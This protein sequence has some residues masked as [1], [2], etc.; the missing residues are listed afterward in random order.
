MKKARPR[1]GARARRSL[2]VCGAT[3]AAVLGGVIE[4]Q[5]HAALAAPA[6]TPAPTSPATDP[7]PITRAVL[8]QNGIGY[9]ERRGA[10][11]GD[12]VTLSVRRDQVADFLKSLTVVDLTS[13]GRAVAVALPNDKTQEKQLEDLPPQ[14]REQGGVLAL[15]QA[16]RGASATLVTM[17][18]QSVNGRIAGVE[19]ISE[20][21]KDAQGGAN[22]TTS[23]WRVTL[24][25]DGKTLESY[26]I[27]EI[28]SLTIDD[29]NLSA[30]LDKALDVDL[31]EEAWAPVDMDVELA[32]A[33]THDIELSYV[34]EMPTWRPAYRLV[35]GDDGKALLQGWAVV[36]NVSGDDWD[37]VKLSLTAGTPLAFAYDLYT[38][39]Y[40][41]RP[42]LT[43]PENEMAQVAPAIALGG[44]AQSGEGQ[45]P[46]TPMGG[47]SAPEGV[48][49]QN[50]YAANIP[51]PVPAANIEQEA[52]GEAA[53]YDEEDE[54]TAQMPMA[55]RP[56]PPPPP[57]VTKQANADNYHEIS[58]ADL[59]KSFQALVSSAGV[60]ALF[61]YDLDEPVSV[62]DRQ[63]ALVSIVSKQV[64]G[65]DVLVYGTTSGGA[66]TNSVANPYR[67][68]LMK[69][70]TGLVL[71]H[72]PI[73][74]YRKD[75]FLGEALGDRIEKDSSVFVPYAVD[76]RVGIFLSDTTGDEGVE[77]ATI[78]NG[79]MTVQS[80]S[81]DKSTYDVDN[82]TGDKATLYV[83]RPRRT[84][85]TLTKIAPEDQD[86][87]SIKSP[88]QPGKDGVIE[89]ASSYFVPIALPESGHLKID[90]VE[91]TPA[92]RQVEVTS[93]DA[94]DAVTA[95]IADPDADP[96][97]TAALKPVLAAQTQ[98]S[99]NALQMNTIYDKRNALSQ[100]ESEIE[101]NIEALSDDDD[102]D[103]L[104]D[105]LNDELKDVDSQL[106]TLTHQ[107]VQLSD[108]NAKLKDQLQQQVAAISLGAPDDATTN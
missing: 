96:Q 24:L 11:A 45:S 100:R 54:S 91:E 86:A 90:V 23:E 98:L 29:S 9:F 22:G 76:S 42:D 69:N 95:Y 77:L 49:I 37:G 74:I 50:D 87:S 6:P 62:K 19:N 26:G 18:G 30:G 89:Q 14:V 41:Q 27:Q 66:V 103:D 63:S 28:R 34:V 32:G 101:S 16:F 71:E 38:P 105:Q 21:V 5:H 39:H 65:D 92:H 88:P 13:G 48:T 52:P 53:D 36:D 73:A 2:I 59:E 56:L 106:Q 25:V 7:L 8:Y 72:G 80:K 85:W 94:L 68:I 15:A 82:E 10:V 75:T 43:P 58:Q 84:G 108:Q 31:D 79:V 46:T 93:A 1:A 4:A 3:V 64:P 35:V 107:Y 70:D 83:E 51:E 99:Q 44:G 40:V 60:G 47:P 57:V 104:R 67:A 61:R 97:V 12:H 55:P 81:T 102:D 20:P 17:A 33:A 78:V